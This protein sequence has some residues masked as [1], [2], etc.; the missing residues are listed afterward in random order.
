MADDKLS[1]WTFPTTSTV[2]RQAHD[3]SR[4][5]TLSQDRR[6]PQMSPSS[7]EDQGLHRSI[8]GLSL[9][10]P[11]SHR[12]GQDASRM[13]Y[14]DKTAASI[15]SSS[16]SQPEPSPVGRQ[17][18]SPSSPFTAVTSSRTTMSPLAS[19]HTTS[20]S[21]ASGFHHSLKGLH[22]HSTSHTAPWQEPA[23]RSD[24]G[25]RQMELLAQHR[26]SESRLGDAR[27]AEGGAS[28]SIN[29]H[30][31]L[32]DAE[33]VRMSSAD[34]H[35]RDPMVTQATGYSSQL[36]G[37]HHRPG[38]F[39]EA[40]VSEDR[41]EDANESPETSTLWMG[42]LEAWMDENYI[43]RCIAALGWDRDSAGGVSSQINVKI[44]KSAST[45]SMYCF[46]TFPTSEMARNVLAQ[47]ADQPPML[48]PGS[49]R[50]FK[51]MSRGRHC[52]SR[53]EPS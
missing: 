48:M 28:R 38:T 1:S 9:T 39:S 8:A 23:A 14:S 40:F 52:Q 7:T 2:Q 11:G 24:C 10:G 27:H 17:S 4:R 29:D 37:Q 13:P 3:E 21:V 18:A 30:A 20:P 5:I 26:R 6:S 43:R 25:M 46:V 50:T 34:E 53:I 15:P 19:S 22:R 47:M 42:D 12:D 33:G 45:S 35:S 41:E 32:N 51:R 31:P 44:I 36:P 49:E 16:R